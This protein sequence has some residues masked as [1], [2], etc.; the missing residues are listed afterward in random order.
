MTA[1]SQQS[2]IP[3]GGSGGGG[4]QVSSTEV[5]DLYTRAE[6]IRY[7]LQDLHHRYEGLYNNQVNAMGDFK[8]TAGQANA[9]LSNLQASA[10]SLKEMVRYEVNRAGS[11]EK[12]EM[13]DLKE[14][15]R[16]LED[17]LRGSERARQ[18]E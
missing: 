13:E 9:L 15:I 6:Q 3:S 4:G 5:Y 12:R 7:S 17:K 10:D 14:K 11:A 16:L 2:R 1:T 8:V 18:S